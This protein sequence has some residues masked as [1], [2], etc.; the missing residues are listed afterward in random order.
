MEER[1]CATAAAEGDGL[2]WHWFEAKATADREEVDVG[3]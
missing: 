1:R 3:L 2:R